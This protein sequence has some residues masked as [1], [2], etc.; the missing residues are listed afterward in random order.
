MFSS[1]IFSSLIVS[2][3][4]SDFS[5][6]QFF[7]IF[8]TNLNHAGEG[9]AG[10][11]DHESETTGMRSRYRLEGWGIVFKIHHLI[12]VRSECLSPRY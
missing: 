9:L 2:S 8:N 7:S 11:S 10:A 5:G 6:L 4:H 12:L 3:A 1:L